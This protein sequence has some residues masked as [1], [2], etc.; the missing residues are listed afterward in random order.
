MAALEGSINFQLVVA[1][2]KKLGIGN[3]GLSLTCL[4]FSFAY[5]SVARLVVMHTRPAHIYGFDQVQ[6]PCQGSLLQQGKVIYSPLPQ[7]EGCLAQKSTSHFD[8]VNGR[9]TRTF[10]NSALLPTGTLPWKIPADMAYFKELTSRTADP[11]KQNAVIMG[12]KTWE[13][14]PPKFRPLAG[15]L[16]IV[17]SRSAAQDENSA[18]AANG[19]KQVDFYCL[20]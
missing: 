19:A 4:P 10:L 14:I 20:H 15:R 9:H 2:T 8:K 7:D 11:A 5:T 17:L 6:D 12:R 3:A 16:N 1:A 13:S 18:G